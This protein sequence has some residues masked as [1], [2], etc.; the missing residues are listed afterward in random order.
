M[1]GGWVKSRGSMERQAGGS[2]GLSGW[3]VSVWSSRV[4]GSGC[5]GTGGCIWG[6][7]LWDE[8]KMGPMGYGSEVSV[9]PEF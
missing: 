8:L 4:L 3:T 5:W 6:F 2:E 9:N 7:G 1:V